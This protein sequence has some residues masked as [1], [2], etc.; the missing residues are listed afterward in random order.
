[1]GAGAVSSNLEC[2]NAPDPATVA[3]ANL[4]PH[5]QDEY[6][7]GM[8]QA[9]SKQ[10]TWGAKLTYR[11]LKNAI[12]DTCPSECRIFNPG[13]DATF[14]IP[15]GDGTYSTQY[16]SAAQLGFPKLKRKYVA[17]DLFTD[18]Q[19]GRWY[20]KV[21][22][23]LSHN[24]GNAEGQLNSSSDTGTG[25]QADVSV[26]QDWDLP[27][28]MVGSNGKLPNNRT[29]QLKA[30]GYYQV[31]DEWRF[32]GSAI[33]QSGRPR[34]CT[35]YWPYAKS[36]IYNGAYYNYCGV[37]GAQTAVNDS[38]VVANAGYT[39]S[40][41]GTAGSTPWTKTINVS[42]S[43][44]PIWAKGLTLQADVMNV[45][46]SQV[47]TAYYDRSASSRSTVAARYGQALYYTDPRSVRFTG[48]YDF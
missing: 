35:S 13:Q 20:G 32:G 7:L 36:G 31:T 43:Y 26:T 28:L 23:T 45:F 21:E 29:H 37:P 24:F 22:Y 17:L 25:G 47:A 9:L 5:Y 3:I 15:N 11:D 12:D 2:G 4:K 30:F 18:Y 16:Y 46:N 14:V 1:V 34:N 44:T 38:T 39:F 42:A 6:I 27:E 8:E 48:R 33:V 19:A 10:W 40:P 41:R